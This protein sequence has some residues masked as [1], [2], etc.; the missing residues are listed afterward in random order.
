MFRQSARAGVV[1]AQIAYGVALLRGRGT[2]CNVA[3]GKRLLRYAARRGSVAA[4][5]TLRAFLDELENAPKKDLSEQNPENKNFDFALDDL[6]F[7]R[8]DRK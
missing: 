1:D 3:K 6:K 8:N 7:A 4:K 5:R 2:V